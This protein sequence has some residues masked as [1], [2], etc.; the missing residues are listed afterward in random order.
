[1]QRLAQDELDG[2]QPGGYRQLSRALHRRDAVRLLSRY[3]ASRAYQP[4]SAR[5]ALTMTTTSIPS[6][7]RA[8]YT[9]GR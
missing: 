5:K 2:A 9:G 6:C 4:F 8:P 1:M 7:N 3:R